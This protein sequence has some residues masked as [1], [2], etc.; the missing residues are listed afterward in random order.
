MIAL[1]IS[2]ILDRGIYYIKFSDECNINSNIAREI[3]R[4]VVYNTNVDDFAY[5][6]D[7]V[8]IMIID[9]L[10]REKGD[11]QREQIENILKNYCTEFEIKFKQGIPGGGT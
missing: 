9:V 7:Y 4:D 1:L 8:F 11:V 5:I 3:I 6:E 10:A 2:T